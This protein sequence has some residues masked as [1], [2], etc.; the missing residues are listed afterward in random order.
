[1]RQFANSERAI[2]TQKLGLARP[3]GIALT[4]RWQDHFI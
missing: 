2:G 4:P 3:I 1:M